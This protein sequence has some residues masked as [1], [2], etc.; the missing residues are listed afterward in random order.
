MNSF[1]ELLFHPVL[2]EAISL[3]NAKKK[4]LSKKY[5]GAYND[6]LDEVFG[7]KNRIISRITIDYSNLDSP[8]M[9]KISSKLYEHMYVIPSMVEYIKGMA[10]K[11]IGQYGDV[12]YKN[13]VKIGKLL[14]KFEADGQIEVTDRKDGKKT[15]KWIT[16]KPLLHEFKTDPIRSSNGEFL[17]VISIHPY[18]IAGASTDRS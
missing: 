5:S 12:D 7:G 10:Y 4:L 13:P 1:E 11:K 8:L 2:Q 18:D 16:G 6:R 14:Q 3:K 17:L 9:K 15:T